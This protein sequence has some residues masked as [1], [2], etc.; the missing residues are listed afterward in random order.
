MW[1][2]LG[3]YGDNRKEN[4]NY[5]S[6]MGYILGSYNRDVRA[7]W[8]AEYVCR[9]MCFGLLSFVKDHLLPFELQLEVWADCSLSKLWCSAFEPKSLGP[10]V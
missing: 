4:G 2:V 8:T 5:Y 7:T 1:Y 10:G 3:L 9:I 6:M